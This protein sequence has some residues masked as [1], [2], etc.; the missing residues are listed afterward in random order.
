MAKRAVIAVSSAACVR[1]VECLLVGGPPFTCSLGPYMDAASHE[2]P[3]VTSG[4]G[5]PRRR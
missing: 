1:G 4:A 2:P 3:P 5:Q